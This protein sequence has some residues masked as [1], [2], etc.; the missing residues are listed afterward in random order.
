MSEA[1]VTSYPA[2]I[3]CPW[4][5]LVR[6]ISLPG[7][8]RFEVDERSERDLLALEFPTM[9]FA[10]GAHL[11]LPWFHIQQVADTCNSKPPKAGWQTGFQKTWS[12]CCQDELVVALCTRVRGRP[13]RKG[14]IK[15][16]LQDVHSLLNLP[17]CV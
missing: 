6:L 17:R 16:D 15:W 14:M 1:G 13:S 3:P 7:N 12:R 10:S 9:K 11:V 8:T 2:M 4:V 5:E